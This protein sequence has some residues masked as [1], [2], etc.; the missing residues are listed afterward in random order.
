MACAKRSVYYSPRICSGIFTHALRKSLSIIPKERE[1]QQINNAVWWFY[2]HH[3]I[4]MTSKTVKIENQKL[5]PS[6]RFAVVGIRSLIGSYYQSNLEQQKWEHV[7][8]S[9]QD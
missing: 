8:A 1:N 7:S 5:E 4:K 9:R 2:T 6:T 3:Q